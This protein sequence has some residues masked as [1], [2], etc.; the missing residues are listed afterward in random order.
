MHEIDFPQL[1][2]NLFVVV[3]KRQAWKS[4][5]ALDNALDDNLK[6]VA[7]RVSCLFENV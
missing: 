2:K 6:A 5:A 4:Y 1:V 7:M 3:Y